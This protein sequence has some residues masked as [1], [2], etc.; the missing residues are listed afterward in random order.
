MN[1]N[2][3][4]FIPT[5]CFNKYD[6]TDSFHYIPHVPETSV[7]W[8]GIRPPHSGQNRNI[9]RLRAYKNTLVVVTTKGTRPLIGT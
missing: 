6:F 1:F 8:E 9:I 5:K 2:K 4:F 7:Q 3:S